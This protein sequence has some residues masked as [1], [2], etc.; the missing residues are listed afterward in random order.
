MLKNG[1]SSFALVGLLGITSPAIALDN[2]KLDGIL[3]EWTNV[4]S[5]GIDGDDVIVANAK[6]DI[7]QVWA[8]VD[9]NNL[10]LAYSND[11]PIDDTWWPW[12][13]FIDTD[14]NGDTGFNSA[15][16]GVGAELLLQGDQLLRY[17]GNGSDW[18]WENVRINVGARLNNNA[19]FQIGLSELDNPVAMNVLFK[20][21]NTVFTGSYENSG[22]DT[23]PNSGA[24]FVTINTPALG[25]ERSH[26]LTVSVDGDLSE[27]AADTTSY[28]RD[29]D[30]ISV[31]GTQADI[32]EVWMANNESNLYI[33]YTNDGPINFDQWWPWQVY[34]DTDNNPETGLQIDGL[35]ADYILQGDIVSS[36][37][38][39]GTDWT[40]DQVSR[41]VSGVFYA[42]N[43]NQVEIALPR[44]LIG[45]PE[46][47]DF[48]V[49][50]RNQPFI[51]S[52]NPEAIDNLPNVGKYRYSM[53]GNGD[54][55]F[56]QFL[57]NVES[58]ADLLLPNSPSL[59]QFGQDS[60]SDISTT[61]GAQANWLS[62]EIGHDAES[63]Y[64]YYFNVVGPI[65]I[66]TWWAWQVYLDTDNNPATGFQ[67]N[68]IGADF[69]L[70]GDTLSSYT[71]NGSDWSW[72]YVTLAESN[73]V[74][75]FSFGTSQAYLRFPHRLL[76]NVRDIKVSLIARNA[77]F[78]G[79]NDDSGVD[80]Y[81]NGLGVSAFTYR[82][83]T[84]E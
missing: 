40:W 44:F 26:A 13:V 19:E 12:Q 39:S 67:V 10:Q 6:A 3:N 17:T 16:N 9:A 63:L 83:T 22:I 5:L 56:S 38:G 54:F 18:S 69:I 34:F 8:S 28:G 25:N 79:S 7:L 64:L 55:I 70:Q 68:G 80:L 62:A 61:S 77:P 73:L 4:E 33:A 50:A 23:F 15:T 71:G 21:S 46:A 51:N 57:S 30:D 31:A 24:G 74:S 2:L 42:E 14:R 72:A 37:S 59:A 75:S 49:K 27:W 60:V 35:G 36:Y 11:G 32:L 82:I 45:S 65:N 52:D 43:T 47:F 81:E 58:L 76:G 20:A 78:T 53:A 1:L 48:I 41:S 29:G 84:T 66:D